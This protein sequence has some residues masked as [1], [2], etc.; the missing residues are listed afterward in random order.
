MEE[1]LHPGTPT[2]GHTQEGL[3]VQA[4][5]HAANLEG[6]SANVKSKEERQASRSETHPGE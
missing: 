6:E 1:K 2:F 4:N 3:Q 5:Q